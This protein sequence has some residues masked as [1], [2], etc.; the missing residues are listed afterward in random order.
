MTTSGDASVYSALPLPEASAPP[1]VP[2]GDSRI[3]AYNQDTTF[4]GCGAPGLL[5]SSRRVYSVWW[6]VL[7]ATAGA[8]RC[9]YSARR[10][11]LFT[12]TAPSCTFDRRKPPSLPTLSFLLCACTISIFIHSLGSASR[13]Q[14]PSNPGSVLSCTVS[15]SHAR[16]A[17]VSER[18]QEAPQLEPGCTVCVPV[19]LVRGLLFTV[20]GG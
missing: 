1:T 6:V 10:L 11:R 20:G 3:G 7:V 17:G 16:R 12:L 18:I 14:T 15:R 19:G 4:R 9:N 5:G 2:V 13:S 8:Y